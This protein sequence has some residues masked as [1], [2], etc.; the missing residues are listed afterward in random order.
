MLRSDRATDNSRG[1]LRLG[2]AYEFRKNSRS[3]SPSP[4]SP[5]GA[6]G[7]FLQRILPEKFT[8]GG[9]RDM[10]GAV[11]GLLTL[12]IGSRPRPPDLDRLW[13]LRRP[14]SGGANPRRQGPAARSRPRRLRAGRDA[15]ARAGAAEP[16]QD[17]RRDLGR[18]RERRRVSSPRTSPRRSRACATGRRPWPN[19]IPRPTPK[20]RRLPPR[21][22][23]STAIGQARL[24]MSFALSNPVS[25]PLI[26]MVVGWATFL[27]CGYGLMSKGN[28]MSIAAGAGRRHRGFERGLSDPRPQQ[29]LFRHLPHLVRAAR[30]GAGGHGQGV[31]EAAAYPPL[32]FV[33]PFACAGG[34]AAAVT[35][36][37]PLPSL[38]APAG[39]PPLIA[40]GGA[41][42][43]RVNFALFLGSFAT[44]AVLYCVQPLMPGF[45]RAFSISPA[46]ASLSL[47]AATGV[48][49]GR[50]GRS[51]GRC[52]TSWGARRS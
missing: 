11:V 29:S 34:K 28:P 19:F 42:F 15:D 44:F 43:W 32:G 4:C 22:R 16:R 14:E 24:Q 41:R 13:R 2:E 21:L 3:A 6:V 52:R 45:A 18:E 23:P 5:G 47:S 33:L 7:L 17:D 50:D 9:P 12:L 25:Y 48:S 31:R 1:R 49:G 39:D 38:A 27:F 10:I 26:L 51:P 40:R 35:S 37:S 20:S 36:T 30:A 8:T 46:A